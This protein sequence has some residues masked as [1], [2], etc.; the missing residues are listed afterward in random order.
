MANYSGYVSGDDDFIRGH[1]VRQPNENNKRVLELTDEWLYAPVKSIIGVLPE[2][3][4]LEVPA[5]TPPTAAGLRWRIPKLQWGVYEF[6]CMLFTM[7]MGVFLACKPFFIK[8][9][10]RETCLCVYHLR[11]EFMIEG[12]RRYFAKH[13]DSG[14]GDGGAGEMSDGDGSSDDEEGNL[15]VKEL[16]KQPGTAR[17]AFVCA[18]DANGYYKQECLSGSCASCG[19]FKLIGSRLEGTGLLPSE[20]LPS[21]MKGVEASGGDGVGNGMDDPEAAGGGAGG[22][23]PID[24]DEGDEDEN[25]AAAGETNEG[26]KGYITYDR[27]EKTEYLLR[28]GEKKSKYDFVTVT[29]P[30][31][32]FWT[33][34]VNY[35][36]FFLNHHDLS[37]WNDEAWQLL[38]KDLEPG[39]VALVMDASE[40]HKHELRREHQSAYFSQVT[41]TLWVAVLRIRV[42]DLGNITGEEQKELLSYFDKLNMQP[43]IRETHFYISG[44]KDKDQGQVQYILTDI[45]N[46]LRGRGRWSYPGVCHKCGRKGDSS[47]CDSCGSP[48]SYYDQEGLSES[49]KAEKTYYEGKAAPKDKGEATDNRTFKWIHA[50]SDGCAAQFKCAVFLLFLS[51]FFT[52]FLLKITWNWFCSAHG[53]CDCDPEG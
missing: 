3:A 4:K 8:K 19:D 6:M 30:I 46:Y 48:R 21:L 49:E 38:K 20:A 32:E 7:G 45:A 2:G 50:F 15:T 53:K 29:V 13:G 22:G 1:V 39:N 44:D 43:I 5:A 35:W 33:D 31:A 14:D 40:A 52:K 27:W 9:G 37:K 47:D 10:R 51:L 23:D 11:F 41:S 24:D 42:E 18:K 34:F 16:L 12:L 17:A 25:A 26:K 28:D 36:G